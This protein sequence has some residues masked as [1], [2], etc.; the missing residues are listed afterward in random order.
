MATTL[1]NTGAVIPA[2]TEPADQAVNNAAFT[3]IDTAI[4]AIDTAGGA[5]LAETVSQTINVNRDV[6]LTGTQRIAS[7]KKPK[8]IIV[9]STTAGTKKMSIG[10]FAN[11]AQRCLYQVNDTG[12]YASGGYGIIIADT[13][14]NRSFGHINNVT[15]TGFDIVWSHGGVGATGTAELVFTIMYHGE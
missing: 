6:S 13:S 11:S 3:A 12:T 9:T 4:G 8:A 1:P 10:S 14:A 2:M 5:H 15:D 7:L